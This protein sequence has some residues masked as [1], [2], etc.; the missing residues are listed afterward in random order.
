MD[1][2]ESVRLLLSVLKRE[3]YVID[4]IPENSKCFMEEVIACATNDRRF[5]TDKQIKG[6]LG[7]VGL[8]EYKKL[9]DNLPKDVREK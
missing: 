8:E 1:S 5:M 3:G 2:P 7:K 4:H 9:F 6:A